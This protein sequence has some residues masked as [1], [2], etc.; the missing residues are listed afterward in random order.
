MEEDSTPLDFPNDNNH[1]E[2]RGFIGST[3]RKI[4]ISKQYLHVVVEKAAFA[5]KAS[6]P[7]IEL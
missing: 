3:T 2:E 6:L 1:P 4:T 5:P 7:L